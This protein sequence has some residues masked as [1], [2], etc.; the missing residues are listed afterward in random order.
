MQD[1]GFFRLSNRYIKTGY[2]AYTGP[3]ILTL[4]AVLRAHV[5]RS[6]EYG[7]YMLRDLVSNRYLPV[8]M[9]QQMLAALTG[10]SKRSVRR[11]MEEMVAKCLVVVIP[12]NKGTES[13]YVLG[14]YDDINSQ[15]GPIRHENY[16]WD[17]SFNYYEKISNGVGGIKKG[18]FPT[19]EVEESYQEFVQELHT[20]CP[21]L[22]KNPGDNLSAAGDKL[23]TA[24]AKSAPLGGQIGHGRGTNWPLHLYSKDKEDKED[25]LS[26]AQERVSNHFGEDESH[27]HLAGDFVEDVHTEIPGSENMG[28]EDPQFEESIK[29]DS[30]ESHGSD[31]D[32]EV[33]ELDESKN[34]AVLYFGGAVMNAQEID[35]EEEGAG[36]PASAG[37]VAKVPMPKKPRRGLTA[38][39]R[40]SGGDNGNGNGRLSGADRLEKLQAA[41]DDAKVKGAVAQK[42]KAEKKKRKTVSGPQ[43]AKKVT[44]RT[45]QKYWRNQV[46]SL[47]GAERDL[48]TAWTKQ[49][50]AQAKVLLNAFSI[51]DLE[52]YVDWVCEHWEKLQKE[53]KID[54]KWPT[55]N[56][57][58]GF[59]ESWIPFAVRGEEPS[60]RNGKMLDDAKR[61]EY[62]EAAAKRVRKHGALSTLPK[63]LQ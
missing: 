34:S 25:N 16:L 22:L 42:R 33:H 39:M 40:K 58:V 12:T 19:A 60:R 59:R 46:E 8:R 6:E 62:E 36:E 2:V 47:L 28:S 9:S 57:L 50:N 27:G 38:G 31:L 23:A 45:L 55:I 3:H 15:R 48:L 18:D 13:C 41:Q 24:V 5:W 43:E 51:Q 44:T 63:E 21:D 56:I 11:Y 54:A 49:Q 4:Y 10:L 37:E 29:L 20:E 17:I 52:K 14:R 35:R 7:D 61:G 30:E 32:L 1:D 53:Y 26:H